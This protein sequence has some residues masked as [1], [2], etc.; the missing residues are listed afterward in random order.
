MYV[1]VCR[2]IYIYRCAYVWVCVCICVCMHVWV[3]VYVCMYACMRVDIYLRFI[4]IYIYIERER[5]RERG[6]KDYHLSDT[7]IFSLSKLYMRAVTL[8][9]SNGVIL[10]AWLYES[11]PEQHYWEGT[12]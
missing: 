4:Y 5:E 10:G 3:C 9:S 12:K 11:N 8:C 2:Y 6:N 1:R 7:H